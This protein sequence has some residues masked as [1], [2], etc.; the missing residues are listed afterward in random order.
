MNE[1]CPLYIVTT[2]Y[3]KKK[4]KI[5]ADSPVTK[6]ARGKKWVLAVAQILKLMTNSKIGLNLC[7]EI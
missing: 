4:E 2:N 5:V 7:I 6:I 3:V 1:N